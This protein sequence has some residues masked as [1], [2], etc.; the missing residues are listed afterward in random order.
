MSRILI[1]LGLALVAIG[2]LWPWIGRLGLGR[3]PGNIV[4]E[5]EFRFLFSDHHR[6]ADQRCPDLDLLAR[7]PMIIVDRGLPRIGALWPI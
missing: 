4:I 5:E 7:Q 6:A 3:L 2:L 1:V